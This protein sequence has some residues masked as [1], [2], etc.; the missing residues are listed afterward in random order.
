VTSFAAPSVFVD[1]FA[2]AMELPAL[3]FP[4]NAVYFMR[5]S[6]PERATK[7]HDYAKPKKANGRAS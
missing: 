1:F 5:H 7:Q 3:P 2:F 4:C 6:L